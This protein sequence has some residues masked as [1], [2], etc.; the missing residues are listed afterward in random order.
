MQGHEGSR[1]EA[2][3][4]RRLWTRA[5]VLL[6]FAASVWSTEFYE[7]LGGRYETKLSIG[8]VNVIWKGIPD[9]VL[10]GIFPE[11]PARPGTRFYVRCAWTCGYGFNSWSA[12]AVSEDPRVAEVD[13]T[14]FPICG[15][16][17]WSQFLD[18]CRFHNFMADVSDLHPNGAL[19]V[20]FAA[21]AADHACDL[22]Q[23]P[24]MPR[25]PPL[26]VVPAA[27][28]PPEGCPGG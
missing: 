17:T 18:Q 12:Y 22:S 26:P 10:I 21:Y 8:S 13:A 23:L 14:A 7:E 16:A 1:Q 24:D 25:Q 9:E 3:G 15:G 5:V 4:G 27:S 2:V 6:A 19:V 11:N 28:V 20:D